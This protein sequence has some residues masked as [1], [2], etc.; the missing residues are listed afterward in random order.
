MTSTVHALTLPAG[1]LDVTVEDRGQGRVVL[2]L[3]GGGGPQ[4]VAAFAQLMAEQR[5]SESSRPFIPA[6]PALPGPTG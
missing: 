4:T 2:L 3:H 6:S 1:S 5:Q